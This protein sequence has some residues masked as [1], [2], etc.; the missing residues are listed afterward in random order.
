MRASVKFRRENS[1]ALS[2]AGIWKWKKNVFREILSNRKTHVR[3]RSFYSLWWTPAATSP[4]PE[5]ADTFPLPF[6][7]PG[8]SKTDVDGRKPSVRNQ[9]T[10]RRVHSSIMLL[11]VD[12]IFPHQWIGFNWSTWAVLTSA[13]LLVWI[14][15][16]NSRYVRLIDAIPGPKGIPIIGNILQVNVDQVGK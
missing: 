14:L 7:S 8:N 11:P 13:V 10:E 1:P 6:S 9:P 5:K 12:S 15:W 2:N 4:S 16:R 3:T